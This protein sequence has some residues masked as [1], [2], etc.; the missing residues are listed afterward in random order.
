VNVEPWLDDDDAAWDALCGE[1]GEFLQTSAVTRAAA[2][3]GAATHRVR[4]LD[5]GGRPAAAFAVLET[6]LRRA[7]VADRAFARRFQVLGGPLLPDASRPFADAAR[8]AVHGVLA[9]AEGRGAVETQWKSSWPAVGAAMPFAAHG[10][11]VAEFGVAWR[12]LP[13]RPGDV[14]ATLSRVHRKA[15]RHAEKSGVTVRETSSAD[16]IL[17]LVDA[18]FR[19]SGL[20]PRNREYL[21]ELHRRLVAAGAAVGL[22]AERDGAALASLLAA[23]CG[24]AVF[25]LFHGRAEGDTHGASNLLHL[26]LF[27][28]A[29]ELGSARVHTGEAALAESAAD[30]ADD[31]H[32]ALGITRFKRHLGFRVEPCPSATFVHRPAARR[33]REAVFGV[34]RLLRGTA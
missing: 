18:S 19:R 32:G 8:H 29:V 13:A 1:R 12:E 22:V 15:V 14:L 2:V 5:D 17:P 20:E 16:D 34:Y 33:V 30:G 25:N 10:F 9:L 31:G 7:R 11:D 6:G 26:R 27:E 21:V 4:V 24:E 23:R 28:R 3:F